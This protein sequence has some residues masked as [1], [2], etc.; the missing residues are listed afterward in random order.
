MQRQFI[1]A[2]PVPAL[3]SFW[4]PGC[5]LLI[6]LSP[7]TPSTSLSFQKLTFGFIIAAL[8]VVYGDIGT[9]PLY[10]LRI[11]FDGPRA[12]PVTSGNILGILSLILWSLI[13]LISIKY[14]VIVL[15]ADNNG[16]GGVLALMTLLMKGRKKS[17]VTTSAVLFLGLFGASLLYGDGLITPVISVLS[18]VEGLTTVAPHYTIFVVPISLVILILLF[19]FQKHGSGKIGAVFGPIMLIWFGIIAM[20][21]LFSVV[22]NPVVLTA[23][24]PRH[25]VWFFIQNRIH[26]FFTLGTVFLVLTGGEAL[27]QDIGHFGK[28][29]IRAGWFYIVFPALILNY[30]GQ[31]AFLLRNP[32]LTGN[33][34]YRLAP[35][36]SLVPLVVLATIATIIASQ[37]VISGVFSLARQTVQLGFFP[38]LSIIHTS[39]TTIGQ[40]Y[41]P[42]FNGLLC[43]G[44]II[45]VLAFK[46]SES[47]AGAYGVAVAMTMLITTVLL[48]LAMRN[49]WHWNFFT[50]SGLTAVFI[51]MNIAFLC[52]TLMKIKD[53]GWVSLVVAAIVFMINIT[54][55]RGR[56]LLS[57]QIMTSAISMK[58]FIADVMTIKPIRVPGLSVF[59]AGNQ[60]GVPRT[61]LH[62]YKHNKI[63]HNN[64]VVLTV[65][66][67]DIP[68]VNKED[69]IHVTVLGSGFYWLTAHF[70]FSETPDIPALLAQARIPGLFFDPMQTTFFL[71]RETLIPV[72]KKG[73]FPNWRKGLF[74]FLSRNA[75]DASKFYCIPPNRVIE[76]GVQI[77]L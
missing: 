40:V 38:R 55:S 54:W 41:V 48:Y 17:L 42:V 21:G 34:F 20:L 77:E 61:L 74:A 59:L 64:V 28:K 30:F 26:G 25:A 9:S 66:T 65:L 60:A 43:A 10:A 11:C 44:A 29:P 24:D 4:F 8:G 27:Y 45:L 1:I 72:R 3:L 57:D 33:L 70:G 14:L 71:G 22:D 67:K 52:A 58:D 19:W 69:R 46:K 68:Y 35:Q 31:G 51:G 37:A 39:N 62:N 76:I 73:H 32:T 23:I 5:N 75:C 7:M 53:G 2:N 13:I 49:L 16:E 18:A 63:L 50:A 47:L 56:R 12:L 15:R 36:W 6:Y